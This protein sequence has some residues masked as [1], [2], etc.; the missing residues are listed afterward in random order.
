MLIR[1]GCFSA[2]FCWRACLICK[3]LC[4]YW[5]NERGRMR[6]CFHFQH[7]LCIIVI[8]KQR[9]NEKERQRIIWDDK[10]FL[11][12]FLSV[13]FL[14]LLSS[15][16]FVCRR[17]ISLSLFSFTSFLLLMSIDI[18]TCTHF[19]SSI[20]FSFSLAFVY[21]SHRGVLACVL[22]GIRTTVFSH[23]ILILITRSNCTLASLTRSNI[24]SLSLSRSL[25]R[26]LVLHKWM[27]IVWSFDSNIISHQF[28][29]YFSSINM[30]DMTTLGKVNDDDGEHVQGKFIEIVS[31]RSSCFDDEKKK[32]K[33]N[34]LIFLSH[35][36]PQLKLLSEKTT[37]IHSV[38]LNDMR[39]ILD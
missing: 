38:S 4:Q 25:S 18:H 7:E 24:L 9:E 36:N 6:F 2:W 30:A 12:L 32:K 13:L 15:F 19:V 33:R 37:S 29:V 26:S 20:L 31:P 11:C 28:Q 1:M 14:L 10:L 8:I 27:K 5:T 16:P 23:A 39:S 21:V 35:N 3:I 22:L 34:L 17:S